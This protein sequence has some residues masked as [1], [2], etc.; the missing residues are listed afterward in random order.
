M[1]TVSHT[2]VGDSLHLLADLEVFPFHFSFMYS[3][4]VPRVAA[5]TIISLC[6][7]LFSS[8]ANPLMEV[9]AGNTET[10]VI[11]MI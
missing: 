9:F 11:R 7:K 5:V 10:L 1:T 3:S 6:V 8:F 2:K 4:Q